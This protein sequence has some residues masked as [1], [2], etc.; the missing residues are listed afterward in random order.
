[1]S[2]NI[3]QTL[4][5]RFSNPL[6]DNHK[7]RIIFWQDPDGEFVDAIDDLAIDNV[8]ILKLTG[9]N[10]FA[11]KQ[12]LS[13]TDTESNYL[14][15]NPL[16]YSDIRDNWLLD[17][18]LYSEE[19]RAD[20]LSIRMQELGIPPTSQMR[21][22]VKIYKKFFDNKERVAKLKALGTDYT[23]VSQLH[24]DV[25][26][27]LSGSEFNTMDGVISKILMD[28]MEISDND[29]LINIR[30]FG[31]EDLFWE[32]L[33]KYIGYE[34]ND[35]NSLLPLATHILLTALSNTM[36]ESCLKGLE[37]FI[38][39]SYQ[40]RCY[41]LVDKW[42]HSRYDD[43]LYEIAR[44]VE[45][46]YK[47]AERFDALDVSDLITSECFPC[48]NECI[49]RKYMTEISEDVIKS[50]DIINTVNRRRTT[51]WSK[52][53]KDYF[54]GLLQTAKM[55]QFYQ[56]NIGGFH[57]AEYSK[58]WK[59]YCDKYFEMDHLYRLFHAAFGRSL[60]GSTTVL[61][62]LYKNVADYVEK[63]YKNW[64]LNTLGSQWTKLVKDE[65]EGSAKLKGIPQQSDFYNLM[66]APIVDS[67]ARAYVIISD[68]L[69]YEVAAELCEHMLKNTRG[70]AKISSMQSI[71]PSVTKFGMAALLPHLRLQM[72]DDGK[73]LCDG[74]PTDS[75]AAREKILKSKNSG[76]VA[77]TYK[78]LLG[79]KQAEKRDLVSN[80][81]VVYIYHNAIDAVGDK[82]LT[83]DQVF[84]ACEQAISEL[85]NLVRMLSNEV[86]ASNILITADHGFLYSYRPLDESDKAEKSLV[87]G[88]NIIELDRRY[89]IADGDCSA[90]HMIRVPMKHVN[91]DHS[92]FAPMD[93]IRMKKQ[94]GGMN[95]VHGG[96]S[97]QE[98]V[99]P[100]I[101]YKNKRASDKNYVEVTKTELQLISQSRKVSNNM[102][103]VEFLQKEAVGGK[104]APATYEIY[105]AD[106]TGDPVSDKKT[107]IADK[108]EPNAADRTFKVRFTL[109]S[110]EFRKTD[111]YYLTVVEKGT[112]NV[113]E[114]TEYTIDIAFANDF[115]D[116]GF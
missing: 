2:I 15:Y 82:A 92:G 59:E 45:Y 105:M 69:R 47:L 80:A 17:I 40:Q 1:M 100:V 33:N 60:K 71:F 50:D 93:Y 85:S 102:F 12:L 106:I 54:D 26:S 27:V 5:K 66:V 51:K 95:Y 107:V 24:I 91:S 97:L 81:K 67:G 94:G 113:I 28:G 13:E 4:I 87:S 20:L 42:M 14:V 110:R 114:Q 96:I 101:E 43:E 57:I 64:Y 8:K 18:E 84:D 35:D 16:S 21:K 116:F 41:S 79:M 63:L 55:H 53:V 52:R 58:L 76:N 75:T 37:K 11:A 112:A 44:K 38:A 30:K 62:D 9:S 73:V 111:T 98:L 34:K 49:I 36:K 78:T 108:T 23:T 39:E 32:M 103:S 88:G 6:E 74:E 68:A 31:D 65:L 83:E 72:T 77:V 56:A 115:D 48:I 86:S 3:E 99:V 25:L 104:V 22:A 61:E 89:V 10:N 70:N 46:K 19:F 109:K 29:A 7:R 90:D